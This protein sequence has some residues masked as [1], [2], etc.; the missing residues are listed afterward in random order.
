MPFRDRNHAAVVLAE[1]LGTY[2]G[3]HPLVLGIPRGG[4]V[5]AAVLARALEGELDVVLVHKLGHPRS[6]EVAVGAADET[7]QVHLLDPRLPEESVSDAY[8]EREAA[9][10]ILALQ[11]RRA[12]YSPVHA[13]A[14]PRGRTVIVVDDGLA[15][16]ATMQAA[17]LSLRHRGAV[18]LVA[19]APIGPPGIQG[20]L[21]PLADDVVC[22]ETP[23]DFSAVSQG[24]E[25][26]PQVEDSE[27]IR[28]LAPP[29]RTAAAGDPPDAVIF[30]FDGVIADTEPLHYRSFQEVLEP[31][32][33]SYSW[34]V[35]LADYVG[36]D[37][38]DAFRYAFKTAGR[39]LDDTR[40]GRLIE[41]KERIFERMVREGGM[42]CYPGVREILSALRAANVP[43]ALCTG[44]RASDIRAALSALDLG[45]AFDCVVTADDVAASKPDPESYL[46]SLAAL[47]SAFPSKTLRPACCVAVEDTPAGVTAARGAGLRVIAVTTTH[48]GSTLSTADAVVD[49]LVQ[50]TPASLARLAER[51]G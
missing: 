16:G 31:E 17:L 25:R 24:Y 19:A 14:D 22:L 5:L 47:A 13:P 27:V 20:A 4:V 39:A 1:A 2:R 3:R 6:P 45:G 10:Q 42:T 29:D 38:R 18:R 46:R 37:D 41:T 21:A 51:R 34:E 26:F 44:A 9:R 48:P 8:V 49:N 40:L 43:V 12:A 36:F 11:A 28:L 7:G 35:Y 23:P 33:L 50:T 32:G 30:D 15:T